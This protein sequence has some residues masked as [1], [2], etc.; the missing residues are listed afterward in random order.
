MVDEVRE[1]L[2][3]AAATLLTHYR[4]LSVTEL[5]QLRAK[6]REANA[7]MRVAKNTL[8]RRAAADAGI[9]GLEEMLTGPTGLVF[10]QEDPVGP[11][12]A[13]RDFA[14]D[15][16]ELVIRGGYLDGA[17]LSEADA[18]K[19][20]DLESREELLAKLAGL[21]YGA[22]ANTARLLQAPLSQQA[23]L[24][25]AL[26]DAGGYAGAPADAS[27][28][29]EAS[30]TETAPADDTPATEDAEATADAPSAETADDAPATEDA[31]ATADAP[32]AETADDAPATE[33][34]EATADAPS[35][36]EA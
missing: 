14:K 22:L 21:M 33:D 19:L 20:A 31:E 15:H 27:D 11:A 6:L 30:A 13:L 32:S 4:G 34:A 18:T 12:K 16:P 7:D 36:D 35:D 26:I 28:T 10:C 23:R 17:V 9:E 8:A 2:S 24:V 25:Q 3:N 5:A 1:G 29:E